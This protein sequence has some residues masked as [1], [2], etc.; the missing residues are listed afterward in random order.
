MGM[1]QD[2]DTGQ[3]RP[4]DA[5]K[6]EEVPARLFGPLPFDPSGPMDVEPLR[7]YQDLKESV[8][9]YGEGDDE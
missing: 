2:Q 9:L 6:D 1:I 5:S 4:Y 3:L 8:S 7:P